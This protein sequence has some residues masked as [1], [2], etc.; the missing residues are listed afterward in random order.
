MN[1]FPQFTPNLTIIQVSDQTIMRVY[2]YS[3]KLKL[4][5]KVSSIVRGDDMFEILKSDWSRARKQVI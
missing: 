2:H 1:H 5:A 3:L 4:A